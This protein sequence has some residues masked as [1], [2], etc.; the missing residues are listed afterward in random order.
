MK[1]GGGGAT[2]RYPF[3]PQ[4]GMHFARRPTNK[5]KKRNRIP[6]V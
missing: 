1:G 4:P 2:L 6:K 5:E 3:Q